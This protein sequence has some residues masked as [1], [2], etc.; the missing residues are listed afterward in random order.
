MLPWLKRFQ[1]SFKSILSLPG[2][3]WCECYDSIF[4][5]NNVSVF[6]KIKKI[7]NKNIQKSALLIVAS[8]QTKKYV[9]DIQ[10]IYLE[11]NGN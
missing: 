9:C 8:S 7:E 10:L 6:C 4:I 1:S 5:Y 11:V 2:I 3:Y